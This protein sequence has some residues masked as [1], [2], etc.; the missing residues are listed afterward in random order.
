MKILILLSRIDQT[1]MTTNTLDLVKGLVEQ[2][3]EVYLIAGDQ[4]EENKPHLKEIYNSFINIGV[5]IKQFKVP[6]GNII[7]RALLSVSSIL[8]IFYYILT[9]KSNVIHAQS[10]YMSFIPW[11]LG[12]KFTSTLHVNDFVKSFKYKNATHLIAIS[13][14]TRDYAIKLFEYK[15]EDITIVNHGVSK[16]F[17]NSMTR[18]EKEKFKAANNIPHNKILI[19]FVGSIEK[20]KGHDLLLKAV[21]ILDSKIREKIHIIFLGSSKDMKT[22][23]WLDKQILETKTTDIVSCFDYQDPKKFYDIFDIFVLPSRLEGFG[24]V[25][26]EAMMSECCVI[27]SSTE[28]AYDQ[29]NHGEDGYIFENNNYQELSS[30]LSNV[31]E[32]ENLRLE[33][34]KKGKQKALKKFTIKEMTRGTIEVYKKVQY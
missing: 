33:I 16:E 13:Q 11:M 4:I 32:N 19:G 22:K 21:E 14:E 24:L 7:S 31:I 10:P 30:I 29:I 12:K 26:V 9:I 3:H 2:K 25:V 23:P 18:D 6:K 20:R 34:A 8:K 27:R 15:K 28:G 1:G 5:K 17:A